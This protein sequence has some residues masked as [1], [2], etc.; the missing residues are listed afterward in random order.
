MLLPVFFSGVPEGPRSNVNC[1]PNAALR[2]RR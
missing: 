2:A 1:A